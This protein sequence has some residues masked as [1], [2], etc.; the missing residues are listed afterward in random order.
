[1]TEQQAQEYISNLTLE[2]KLKLLDLLRVIESNRNTTVK[3]VAA[4]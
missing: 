1:M 2:E 4:V 3:E